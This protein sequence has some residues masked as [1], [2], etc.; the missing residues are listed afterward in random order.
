M[1]IRRKVFLLT[2][3]ALFIVSFS[4]VESSRCLAQ[5]DY[6]DLT[7]YVDSSTPVKYEA[8]LCNWF[9]QCYGYIKY[10]N[11]TIV[12]STEY[13]QDVFDDQQSSKFKIIDCSLCGGSISKYYYDPQPIINAYYCASAQKIY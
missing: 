4:L 13:C 11:R 1:A 5:C 3:I 10:Y 7:H 9:T 6:Y 2:M 8:V 12:Y